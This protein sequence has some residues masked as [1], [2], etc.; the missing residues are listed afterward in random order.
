MTN[1][2][3]QVFLA[4]KAKPDQSEIQIQ[5]TI[6]GID[7]ARV[8]TTVENLVDRGIA[9]KTD[10]WPRYSAK[11][12]PEIPFPEL[13]DHVLDYL[14]LKNST[15]GQWSTSSAELIER[16]HGELSQNDVD[17]IL[18][19]LINEGYVDDLSSK[20]GIEIGFNP[21]TGLAHRQKLYMETTPQIHIV[22]NNFINNYGQIEGGITQNIE[23]DVGRLN[24]E[25]PTLL[26]QMRRLASS[27]EHFSA[28]SEVS[29]AIQS[30]NSGDGSKALIHL[31]RAGFWALSIA[32]EIGVQYISGLLSK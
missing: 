7:G 23:A 32:K 31:K 1:L 8:I 3:K 11:G 17:S 6:K 10:D 21:N 5:S 20:D 9:E 25:L 19:Y 26:D 14:V 22:G 13:V 15:G 29:S 4:L 2:E 30:S 18:Q 16:F 12:W 27:P 28:L 24:K